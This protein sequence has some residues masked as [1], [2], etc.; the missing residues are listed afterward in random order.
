[1]NI[2]QAASQSG[3]PVKTL[4][5]YEEIGL[6]TPV[7]MEANDYRDYSVQDVECLRFLQ[8]SRAV[9]FGLDVCRELLELYRDENRRCAQ[10]KKLVLEKIEQ[11]ENQLQELNAL[12]SVLSDMANGC[13][14]DDSADCTIIETLA[15]S[16]HSF[17]PFMLVESSHE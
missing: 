8:R 10:V 3:L 4:R 12:K 7:R 11:V 17:M 6:V 2:G 14:G 15:Q 5:Y 16:K 1:M 9:G 13:A